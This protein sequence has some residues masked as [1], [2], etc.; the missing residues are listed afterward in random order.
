[1]PCILWNLQIHCHIHKSHSR[2][3]ILSEMNSVQILTPT[4]V[5]S[6]LI[7]SLHLPESLQNGLFSLGI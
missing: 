5:I 4:F 6:I 1:M 2:N 3:P 7:L